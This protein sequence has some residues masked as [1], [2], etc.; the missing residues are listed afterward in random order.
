MQSTRPIYKLNNTELIQNVVQECQFSWTSPWDSQLIFVP[1]FWPGCTLLPQGRE[2]S[3]VPWERPVQSGQSIG[4]K[5]GQLPI[6]LVH[7]DSGFWII[8]PPEYFIMKC[9]KFE[10]ESLLEIIAHWWRPKPQTNVNGNAN[11]GSGQ[12]PT[13]PILL[14]SGALSDLLCWRCASFK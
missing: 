14:K 13:L 11:T 3:P 4:E 7:E 9:C 12:K 5:N 6:W 1:T 10:T 2:G 8:F